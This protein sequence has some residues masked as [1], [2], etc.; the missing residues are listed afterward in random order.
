MT[1][2][3]EASAA[4]LKPRQILRDKRMPG[5]MAIGRKSTATTWAYQTDL[6][7]NGEFIRTVRVTLGRQDFMTLKQARD[8]AAEMR[9]LIRKGIDPNQKAVSAEALT[10][11]DVLEDHI[12]QRN[13]AERTVD[14]YRKH[15]RCDKLNTLYPLRNRMAQNITRDDVR[16]LRKRLVKRSETLCA[17]AL[18]VLRLT[19]AHAMRI[20]ESIRD[21][22]VN[23]VVIPS[24][25]RAKEP[26][27]ATASFSEQVVKLPSRTRSLWTAC[28]LTGARP[29]SLL[30]V[31]GDDVNLDGRT[32]RFR[33]AKR[34]ADGAILPI[35]DRLAA[36]LEDYIE[37][38][39]ADERLWPFAQLRRPTK[40]WP[41]TAKQL[42]HNFTSLAFRADV[43]WAEQRMLMLHSLPG[44]GAIYTHPDALI[45]HLRQ[46]AKAI[47]D[48]V[49]AEA[50]TLFSLD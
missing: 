27:V 26:A 11:K 16:D 40:S 34:K 4:A 33:H 39:R 19:M 30:S 2:L 38:P 8:K 32:I 45:E 10:L 20:D 49:A 31:H 12:N 6:R 47:E 41:F 7:R 3:T 17:A 43:P 15:L 48:L 37:E 44:I 36:L 9:A 18:R 42:R 5:L 24:V 28:L 21:N 46:Y 29:A 23:C 50:P 35:G 14:E 13:L 22:P 1:V 25:P